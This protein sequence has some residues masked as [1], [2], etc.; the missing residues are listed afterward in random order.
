MFRILMMATR[1]IGINP[2]TRIHWMMDVI[3]CK[4]E[5]DFTQDEIN[6]D[7]FGEPAGWCSE[8]KR[9]EVHKR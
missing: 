4:I 1:Y 8:Y 7:G 6:Q 3:W 2:A 5:L 9:E